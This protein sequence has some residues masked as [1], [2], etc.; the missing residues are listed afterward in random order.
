MK[1][2]PSARR[3][4]ALSGS[5]GGASLKDFEILVVDDGSTDRTAEIAERSGARVLRHPVNIGYGKALL[6][7]FEN[8]HHPWILTT[9]ADGSYPPEEALKLL[10][11]APAC[12]MVIGARQGSFFW[13]SPLK[14]FLRWIQLGLSGFVAGVKIPDAN[15]GLRLMRRSA[16]QRSLPIRCYGYSL[17]T[18]MTLSFI[19]EALFVKFV[20][21]AYDARKGT[22]KIRIVRDTLRTLQL[23]LEII[24]YFNP[25][26]FAVVLALLP[27]G[28]AGFYAFRFCRHGFMADMALASIAFL[29]ALFVFLV[30]CLLNSIRLYSAPNSKRQA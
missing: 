19:Q 20:P 5:W 16:T 14:T 26:K 12:D 18:T 13:G 10:P 4:K 1:R 27:L 6:T 22:S 30:G 3:S 24:L 23:M 15:S 25:L 7:G 17:S 8:A 21:V 11:H 28:L 2:T 29:S 9:D